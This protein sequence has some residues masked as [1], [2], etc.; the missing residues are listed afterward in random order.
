MSIA[1]NC[2]RKAAPGNTPGIIVFSGMICT[3]FF[4]QKV[5]LVPSLAAHLF[6]IFNLNI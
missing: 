3:L 4:V 5:R 6:Q 2:R 1:Q